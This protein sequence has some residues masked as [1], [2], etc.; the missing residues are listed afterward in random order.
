MKFDIKNISS[1]DASAFFANLVSSL[2]EV[3]V[4]F[5]FVGVLFYVGQFYTVDINILAISDFESRVA[6]LEQT[7]TDYNLVDLIT[8]DIFDIQ[9]LVSSESIAFESV[10]V[11]ELFPR[12]PFTNPFEKQI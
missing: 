8:P 6:S 7:V 1:F 9:G 12:P 4:Y 11:D 5:V 10:V 2:R 3:F